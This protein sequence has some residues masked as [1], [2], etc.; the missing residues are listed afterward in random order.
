[1]RSMLEGEVSPACPASVLRQHGNVLVLLDR[2]AAAG[3]AN[4]PA[5]VAD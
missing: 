4:A 2:E 3:L 1:V 5:A